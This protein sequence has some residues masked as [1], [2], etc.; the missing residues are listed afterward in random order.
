MHFGTA[1]L[2]V[3][4][5]EHALLWKAVEFQN[6]PAS[7]PI[8][9]LPSPQQYTVLAL[10]AWQTL[11]PPLAYTHIASRLLLTHTGAPGTSTNLTP[12]GHRPIPPT[13]TTPKG[14][15]P[16]PPVAMGIHEQDLDG[17]RSQWVA[18]R[19][20]NHSPVNGSNAS[21]RDGKYSR[22]SLYVLSRTLLN[23]ILT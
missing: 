17:E 14:L 5:K 10:P 8:P 15:P 13:S 3:G 19:L 21:N 20:P 4:Y 11:H 1:Y 7:E 6:V 23:Q 16:R 22:T 9:F 2:M 18:A 12:L